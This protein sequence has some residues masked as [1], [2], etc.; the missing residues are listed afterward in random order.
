MKKITLIILVLFI[1]S[2]STPAGATGQTTLAGRW[3]RF[4]SST[5]PIAIPEHETLSCGGHQTW[6]CR[7]DKQ[8]EPKLGY[9]QPPDAAYGLFTGQDVTSTWICPEWSPSKICDNVT[10]AVEGSIDYYRFDDLVLSTDGALVVT[11]INGEQV[12]YFYWINSSRGTFACPWYRSF[13][14]ALAA[15]ADCDYAPSN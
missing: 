15:P 7:Y 4:N 5:P 1:L 11:E 12:L 14:A 9:V 2:F 6:H 8:P 3:D 10:Y 13:D